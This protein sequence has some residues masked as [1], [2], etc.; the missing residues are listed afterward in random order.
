MTCY[1]T[2]ATPTLHPRYTR[3]RMIGPYMVHVP[4]A[5]GNRIPSQCEVAAVFWPRVRWDMSVSYSQVKNDNC[6]CATEKPQAV[7]K[8]TTDSDPS[9]Y[10]PDGRQSA[11]CERLKAPQHHSLCVQE[12]ERRFAPLLNRQRKA[13]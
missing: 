8:Y 4:S 11:D 13:G 10:L 12:K 1:N 2:H 7:E 3:M 5:C 9:S 6:C